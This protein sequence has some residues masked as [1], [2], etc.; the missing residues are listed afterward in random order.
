MKKIKYVFLLLILCITFLLI[1][2][3]DNDRI[4][5]LEIRVTKLQEELGQKE[6]KIQELQGDLIDANE[7]KQE[8]TEVKDGKKDIEKSEEDKIF[9]IINRYI[10]AVEK[11]NYVEQKKYVAKYALDFVNLRE[12]QDKRAT[13]TKEINFTKQPVSKLQ[14]NNNYA[15]AFMSFTENI[16]NYDGSEY[17]LITEGDVFLEKLNNEWKIIDYTRKNRLISE[18]LFNY[19]GMEVYGNGI[20]ITL[21]YTL[22]SLYDKYVWVGISIYNGTEKN[23]RYYSDE[24]ILVGPDKKQIKSKYYDSNMENILQDAIASGYIDFNWGYDSVDNFTVNTGPINDVDGYRF[25]DN[26]KFEIDLDNAVR[27]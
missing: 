5:E 4:E 16:I 22:F 17:D 21:D 7:T 2:C 12:I 8:I 15:E 24:A 1:S 13:A 3:V 6:Q 23:L 11:R 27:Y 26:I 14:V 9:D 20:V 25:I 18:A 19:D 10:D